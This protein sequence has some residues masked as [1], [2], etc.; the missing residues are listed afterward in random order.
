MM[1][2]RLFL[3]GGAGVAALAT[4]F[5][6]RGGA[7][8][9]QAAAGTFPVSMSEDEW[10]K[11]LTPEQFNVLREQGTERAFTSPLNDEKHA[12]V[13]HCAGCD[14]ALFDSRTK[15]DSGTGW[16]SFW[17]PIEK[18]IGEE[19]DST[20][21]MIRTEVHCSRCGGHQGHVFNDGPQPTG[22]RYCINGLALTFKQAAA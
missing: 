16:P 10:R 18:A 21:G 5:A 22:L 13:F 12:G 2:R 6:T 3:L 7:T 4:G 9:A 1:D 14:Q 17:A 19:Q 20:F 15:F 8:K 11:K